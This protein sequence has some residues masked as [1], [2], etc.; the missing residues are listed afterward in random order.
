M[1][2]CII[3]TSCSRPSSLKQQMSSPTQQEVNTSELYYDVVNLALKYLQDEKGHCSSQD[4]IEVYL[5]P[6]AIVQTWNCYAYQSYNFFY[7]YSH[8]DTVSQPV[9]NTSIDVDYLKRVCQALHNPIALSKDNDKYLYKI[10]WAETPVEQY[11]GPSGKAPL[12]LS[13]VIVSTEGKY[14]I[15]IVHPDWEGGQVDSFTFTWTGSEFEV[16]NN[17]FS[18]AHDFCWSREDYVSRLCED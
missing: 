2:L 11:I 13:P 9:Y 15:F 10:R 6:Q 4:I 18:F 7:H 1:L 12:V 3:L 17:Y 16:S 5:Y 14:Q 8:I